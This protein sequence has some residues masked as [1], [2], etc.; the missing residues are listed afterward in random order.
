MKKIFLTILIL[1][2]LGLVFGGSFVFKKYKPADA[3]K[4][5]TFWSIQLKPIYEKPILKIIS[6][7][8]KNHP[9]LQVVWVDIPIQEAQKRTLAS[10]LSSNPPDLINLNP[11]F[12][13]LLAQ[14]NALHFF[15][16]KDAEQFHPNLVN[17]LRY[18]DE[19]YALPFYATSP[20]TIYNKELLKACG[21]DPDL[22]NTYDDLLKVSKTKTCS[23]PLFASSINENDAFAKI[24][25]KYDVSTLSNAFEKENAKIAYSIFNH[26]YKTNNLPK[27]I[28]ATN[29][30]EIVEKYMS[31]KAA[32]IVAG[33]NFINM[34]KQN[35]SG[36]YAKSELKEQ[37]TGKNGNYDIALMNLIIPKNSK[38][39]DEAIEF[40][41]K[42]LDEHPDTGLDLKACVEE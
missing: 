27:D 14:R 21:V 42:Y 16:E 41:K 31:E 6:E 1:L 39:M 12:S 32:I 33:S 36:I 10:V 30:R 38:N 13:I 29:H 7:F 35:A 19:I 15:E 3:K 24:L 40:A 11:D 23:T 5:F 37:L 28:L 20:V 22:I 2:C 4:K 26:L 9:D 34:V 18:L 25:N 17:K 8:E